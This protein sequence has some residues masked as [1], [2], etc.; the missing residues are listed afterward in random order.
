MNN[1]QD[2]K[3]YEPE[4]LDKKIIQVFVARLSMV[5]PQQSQSFVDKF[6]CSLT[7]SRPP[8]IIIII[9]KKKK[10]LSQVV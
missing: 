5:Q 4:S 2:D 8:I 7:Y 6:S 10:I 1:V 9:W 3:R